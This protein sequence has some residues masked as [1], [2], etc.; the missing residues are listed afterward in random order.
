[1]PQI[2]L[3]EADEI[4]K[5]A[6]ENKIPVRGHVLVWHS[7]TP[8][9]FFKENFDPNG[10][11]VSKDKMTKRLENY[12]KTVMETLKKDYP[13][14]E[15]YAWDVVNEA[16]S[17]AGTIRDAGSN[18]EVD[19]QSAWVKVYGDQSYISLAFEFAKKYA[20]AGCKLF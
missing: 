11:W 15:F 12:I 19:G 7:Q 10:A 5:F 9:W 18:N 20:P 2:S 13:D 14:V 3:N 16:A 8:D 4:L 17:D 6:G 1:M